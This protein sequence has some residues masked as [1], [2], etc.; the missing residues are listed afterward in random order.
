LPKEQ[1]SRSTW[2]DATVSACSE[3]LFVV[4][5]LVVVTLVAFHR[6]KGVQTLVV[7]AEWAF[8]AAV[9]FGQAIV[10]MITVAAA[11]VIPERVSFLGAIAMVGG[12]VPSL[13]VLSFV[14]GEEHTV[15]RALAIGQIV[16]FVIAALVYGA[17]AATAHYALHQPD[18]PT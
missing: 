5:P 2:V 3:I 14:L 16:L 7:S 10:K 11:G 9:L 17:F 1:G 6:G 8:A 4:L 12:L 13:I 18:A 15:S